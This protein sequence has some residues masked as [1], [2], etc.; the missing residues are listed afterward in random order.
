MRWRMVHQRCVQGLPYSK[1]ASNL[2]VDPTTVLRTVKLF[3]ETSTVCSIQGYRET[4]EKVLTVLDK[5]SMLEAIVENPSLFLCEIQQLLLHTTGTRISVPTI[6]KYLQHAGFSHKKL[7][8]RACQRS[9]S[10]RQQYLL[11]V[12]VYDPNMLVFIDECGS[13]RKSALRKYGYALRGKR[14]VTEKLLLKGKHYTA[15]G[16]M[17]IDGMLDVYTTDGTVNGETFCTFIERNLLPQLLPFNGTN[18]RSVVIMDN[19]A[20]HHVEEAVELIESTGAIIEFL[21]PYSPDLNPI[22]EAFSKVKHFLRANEPFVQV[23][24]DDEIED[25][26]IAGFATITTEDC[27][28]WMQHSGYIQ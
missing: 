24:N 27:I 4:T 21:P 11:Q 25:V 17:C 8:F 26:I 20:I 13:D 5:F 15:I 7:M 2:N 16:I 10:L 28:G 12:S 18:P 23:C 3:E 1:I 19:A 6:C 22:E 14:A 9:E